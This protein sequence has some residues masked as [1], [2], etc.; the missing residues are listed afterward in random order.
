M[1]RALPPDSASTSAVMKLQGGHLSNLAGSRV[2]SSAFL[3]SGTKE[4]LESGGESTGSVLKTFLGRSWHLERAVPQQLNWGGG[5]S[6]LEA[7][8]QRMPV[9]G[10]VWSSHP[11]FFVSLK[12]KQDKP[13]MTPSHSSN[14]FEVGRP[15]K[16]KFS[17]GARVD[18]FPLPPR[19]QSQPIKKPKQCGLLLASLTS[20]ACKTFPAKEAPLFAGKKKYVIFLTWPLLLEGKEK[21]GNSFPETNGARDSKQKS[22]TF[23]A[24]GPAVES[25][26]SRIQ[27]TENGV[28]WGPETGAGC[29]CARL[30]AL[31]GGSPVEAAS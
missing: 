20:L 30:C 21:R 18:S 17:E 8:G 9:L 22:S 28:L 3:T 25:T 10:S 4:I 27:K 14:W 29:V 23:R 19:V 6:S 16:A 7:E 13:L 31:R 2:H 1:H 15:H 11:G 5:V 24:W 26:G 12:E